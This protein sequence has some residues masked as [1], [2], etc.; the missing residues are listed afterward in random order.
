MGQVEEVLGI[1]LDQLESDFVSHLEAN[2]GHAIID[3]I[4][5]QEKGCG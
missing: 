4:T 3:W 1:S 5:L 2:A